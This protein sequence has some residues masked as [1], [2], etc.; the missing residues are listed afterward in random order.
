MRSNGIRQNASWIYL[1]LVPF[2][3]FTVAMAIGHISYK[4]YVPL[5][6]ANVGLMISAAWIIGFHAVRSQDAEKKQLAIGGFLL[7][8]PLLFI[9][10]FFG[11]GP[12]PETIAEWAATATEQ[13]IR[14]IMLIISGVFATFGFAVVKEKLRSTAGGFY[15]LIAYAA[16]LIAIPLFI[17]N[18]IFWGAYLPQLFKMM[19]ASGLQKSPEWF[20]PL[21]DEF[22]L[23]TPVETVIRYIGVAA[24]AASV[25]KAGIFKKIPSLIYIAVCFTAVIIAVFPNSS[26]LF[27]I[28]F[29]IVTIPANPFIVAYYVGINLLRKT[30]NTSQ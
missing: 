18:M 22:N 29:F 23:L 1:V 28:P 10:M 16:I 17:F 21:R 4:I 27:P 15:S 12:P 14:F 20:Q 8:A 3:V 5:W 19:A 11:L 13:R 9:S 26:K 6:V 30:G 7:I 25:Y 24:L 2:W